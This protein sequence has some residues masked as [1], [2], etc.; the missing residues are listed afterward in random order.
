MPQCVKFSHN[1]HLIMLLTVSSLIPEARLEYRSIG[2]TDIKITPILMGAWQSGKK[3]WIGI[4]DGE[5]TRAI[6]IAYETGINAFDT[7]EAYG[8]GHSERILGNALAPMRN[9]V[10]YIS[11]PTGV[12]PLP[13][14]PEDRLYR[15]L[16]GALAGRVLENPEDTDR[17]DDEGHE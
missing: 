1:G 2:K 7:A 4:E 16:H 3:D 11:S 9:R 14:K 13:E 15:P 10:V 6:Q 8:K 12:S 17:G 5:S